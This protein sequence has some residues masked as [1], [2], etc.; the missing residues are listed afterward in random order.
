[1]YETVS[2]WFQVMYGRN[3]SSA[4]ICEEVDESETSLL[5]TAMNPL[6]LHLNDLCTVRS[7]RCDFSTQ[8]KKVLELHRVPLFPSILR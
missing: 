3:G 6:T 4:R 5:W 2:K 8:E 1:M 7:L